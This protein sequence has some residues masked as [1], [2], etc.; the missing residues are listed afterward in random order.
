M[1]MEDFWEVYDIIQ[2]DYF[3]QDTVKKGDLVR[4]AII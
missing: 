1:N 4:G 2:E 3:S